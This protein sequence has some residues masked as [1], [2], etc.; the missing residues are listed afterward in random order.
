[1]GLLRRYSNPA[2]G[3]LRDLR[4]LRTVLDE[5]DKGPAPSLS[6]NTGRGRRTTVR[7]VTECEEPIVE[8]VQ[9]LDPATWTHEDG[10][11]LCPVVGTNGYEAAKPGV[12]RDG[13]VVP[14]AGEADGDDADGSGPWVWIAS[15]ADYTNGYLHGRWVAADRD[16]EDLQAAVARI[17]ATSP[18]RRHGEEAEEWAVHDY[19]GF[20][21]D[22]TRVLGEWPSLKDL[23]KVA[24][25]IPPRPRAGE[26]GHGYQQPPRRLPSRAP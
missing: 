23:S 1:M 11:P 12:W 26:A 18:A 21:E 14:L 3:Y 15:L 6:G 9:G 16:A 4:T 7:K 19:E 22:V 10:E 8:R 13:E 25:G 2:H 17:L 20:E 5:I 24:R